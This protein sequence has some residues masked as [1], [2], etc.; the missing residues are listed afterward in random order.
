MKVVINVKTN[1]KENAIQAISKSHYT[2]RL[3][4]S[5][6]QGKANRAL[7]NLLAGYF[8]VARDRITIVSGHSS[9]KKFIEIL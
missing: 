4:A 2:V 1:A 3:K 8:D 7:I 5:P 6:V 9:H